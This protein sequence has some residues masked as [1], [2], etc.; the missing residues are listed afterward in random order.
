LNSLE[1]K[2]FYS[3]L[4]LYIVS[5]FLFI[6]LSAYWYFTAQKNSFQSNQYYKLQHI[7]DEISQQIIS[8]HMQGAGFHIPKSYEDIDIALV[9]TKGEIVYGLLDKNI[10]PLQEG[11]RIKDKTSVLISQGPQEHLNIKY[12]VISSTALSSELFEEKIKVI[13]IAFVSTFVMMLLA[14]F[15]SRIFMRPLHEKI[16]QIEDFVHDTAHELNTPITAL[17]MSVSR[18]M[19][20][21]EYDAKILKN[22]SISTKQL[23]NIYNSL[24]YLSFDTKKEEACEID[25]KEAVEKSVQYYK[26]LSESKGIVLNLEVQSFAYKI[27]ERKS[28]MLFGNLI[29][30]A[31]KYSG[32]SSKIDISLI[33]GMFKIQDYGIGIA[34]DKL[35]KIYEVYNRETHYAGGFGVGLSIVEKIAK[36]YK[37]ELKVESELDEGSTFSLSFA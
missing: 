4:A 16:K 22:I 30:N 5:S 28:A 8:A 3:F 25:L 24:S 6:V 33:E 18:A 21:E 36:E 34:K 29:N 10:F 14:W 32:P 19:K 11:Y 20:K 26:E 13:S 15:L 27:D 37:I 23:F 17:S 2:S 1:K 9:D 31:I 35:S 12:V 7:A